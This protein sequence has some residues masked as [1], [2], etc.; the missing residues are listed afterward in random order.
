MRSLAGPSSI[1]VSASRRFSLRKCGIADWNLSQLA[2]AAVS[3]L[4]IPRLDCESVCDI[5]VARAN[6]FLFSRQTVNDV[7]GVGLTLAGLG[8]CGSAWVHSSRGSGWG[9]VGLLAAVLVVAY[10]RP[11]DRAP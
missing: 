3:G 9:S 1:T 11:N 5:E 10:G 2:V 8:V 7:V 4:A 6:G